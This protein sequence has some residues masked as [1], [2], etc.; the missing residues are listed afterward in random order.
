[1]TEGVVIAVAGAKGG[2]GKTTTSIN[3]GT[4]AT[5][6]MDR[7]VLLLEA[8]LAMANVLDFLDLGY[9]PSEDPDLHDVLADRAGI[10]E[11]TYTA[12]SGLHIL[13]SGDS[14]DG[15]AQIDAR[16]LV[17]TVEAVRSRYDVVVVDTAA[18]VSLKTL[19]PLALADGVVLVSTPRVSAVRDTKK[20][21]ELIE[22]ADG[23]AAGIVIAQTGSGSAPPP[24]RLADFLGVPTATIASRTR[25]D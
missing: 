20:T 10:D 12:A 21:V 22:R 5:I 24:D 15:L 18:G 25:V 16:S 11:A 1:M 8:D 17:P 23:E 13:P 2:V 9:Q 19:L 4:V 3:L 7:S 6:A 14:L